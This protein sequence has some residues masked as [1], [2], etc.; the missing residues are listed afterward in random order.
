[1][2]K[3]IKKIARKRKKDPYVELS[4]RAFQ[5]LRDQ[6]DLELRQYLDEIDLHPVLVKEEVFDLARR[7]QE[8][9]DQAA[10]DQ[11]IASHLKLVIKVVWD[12][13]DC[14]KGNVIDLI[15]EGNVGLVVALKKFNP[16]YNVQ[17]ATYAYYWINTYVRRYILNNWRPS[18]VCT[19][20][21]A[22]L[23]F[24]PMQK[25]ERVLL[26][27]GVTGFKNHLASRLDMNETQT[28]DMMQRIFGEDLSLDD[29][30]SGLTPHDFNMVMQKEQD[31]ESR[32]VRMDMNERVRSVIRKIKGKLCRREKALLQYR[33]LS[34]ESSSLQEVADIFKLSRE[35]MRQ[36]ECGLLKKLKRIFQYEFDESIG[37]QYKKITPIL[38]RKGVNTAVV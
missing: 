36:I 9:K 13:S 38:D 34:E 20:R 8:K 31:Q 30:G 35:R 16:S 28:I 21:L 17:F 4:E 6:S 15:Q 18:K 2:Y 27:R 3:T 14:W 37:V 29:Y 5:F 26:S 11:L 33:L 12:F 24:F 10:G 7:F 25:E 32:C 1:M 19:G 22:R 23:L